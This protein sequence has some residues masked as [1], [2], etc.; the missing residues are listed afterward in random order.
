[1]SETNPAWEP[2]EVEREAR[3]RLLSGVT[4]LHG[5]LPPGVGLLLEL[6]AKLIARSFAAYAEGDW[7]TSDALITEGRHA[8]GDMFSA[9]TYQVAS[10]AFPTALT[11]R[12]GKV[13]WPASP[14]RSCARTRHPRQRQHPPRR[15]LA[16]PSVL[17]TN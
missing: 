10:P 13:S 2:G 12:T 4:G 11:S 15:R 9:L 3:Q 14:S 6:A 17:P 1:M 7:E 5:D 8:C 16:S